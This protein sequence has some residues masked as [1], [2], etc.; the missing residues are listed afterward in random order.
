[1]GTHFIVDNITSTELEQTM[2]FISSNPTLID[3]LREL[4]LAD[5]FTG[6][7][8]AA[9]IL[10]VAIPLLDRLIHFIFG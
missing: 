3:Q 7:F 5:P 1:M 8:I 4:Y 9:G 10:M 2:N 6:T